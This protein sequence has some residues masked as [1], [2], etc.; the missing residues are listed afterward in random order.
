M[1]ISCS[2]C[3]EYFKLKD[4]VST[5]HCG[6]I[7][8]T[9][10]IT[11][12]LTSKNGKNYCPRCNENCNLD[13]IF[14][15]YFT[16]DEMKKMVLEQKEDMEK[17][18]VEKKKLEYA[19]EGLASLLWAAK[20]DHWDIYEMIMYKVQ[21]K[22]PKMDNGNTPLHLAARGGHEKIC[23]IIINEVQ[24]KNPMN[25]DGTTPLHLA[26]KFGHTVIFKMIMDV[27][28]DKNPKQKVKIL[29]LLS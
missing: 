23:T 7:F 21:E 26:A 20:N 12:Y 8:H 6:H 4:N 9:L 3:L 17:R 15:I 29:L 2:I 5:T 16:E 24:D 27:V 14:K 28:Q 18:I 13:K 25:Q 1:D 11:T 19:A 22:N 10:C